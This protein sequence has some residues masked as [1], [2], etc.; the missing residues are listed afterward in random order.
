MEFVEAAGFPARGITIGPD[1]A[2]WFACD[3]DAVGRIAASGEST[4][5]NDPGPP[6]RPVTTLDIASGPHGTLWFTSTDNLIG[7]INSRGVV[8]NF[9]AKAID[10]PEGITEGPDGALWFTNSGGNSIGRITMRGK[11]TFYRG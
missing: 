9:A 1:G 5:Y 3:E 8:T 6:G 2:V 7:R 10:Y 4:V 11:I